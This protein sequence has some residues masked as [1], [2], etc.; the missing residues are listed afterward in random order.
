MENH[1]AINQKDSNRKISLAEK[2][3]KI[4]KNSCRKN[5]IEL[6]K[7]KNTHQKKK[8]STKEKCISTTLKFQKLHRFYSTIRRSFH[9][10]VTTRIKLIENR[11][12]LDLTTEKTR[13]LKLIA[14]L[15]TQ[16]GRNRPGKSEQR[17][18]F[19]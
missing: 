8:N 18:C 19:G 7:N 4:K 15:V 5:K 16:A 13:L 12:A 10:L 2:N 3:G 6:S 17:G 11:V 9:N 14:L 1:K